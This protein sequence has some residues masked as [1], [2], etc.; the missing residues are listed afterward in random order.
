M[1]KIFLSDGTTYELLPNEYMNF[2][3]MAVFVFDK[4][5][6]DH[7]FD[8]YPPKRMFT[9]GYVQKVEESK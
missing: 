4:P 5:K 6:D 1:T 2:G 3:V 7:G 9:Y 8:I